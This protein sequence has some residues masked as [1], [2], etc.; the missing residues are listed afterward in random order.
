MEKVKTASEIY[1]Q[2]NTALHKCFYRAGFPYRQD[3]HVWLHLFCRI[4][5]R[6]VGGL[7]ELT[8]GERQR[9][10]RHFQKDRGMRVFVPGVP[11]SLE[12]WKKGDPESGFCFSE[13]EDPQVRMIYGM[14]AEM[15]Y[16][17]KALRGMVSRMFKVSDVRWLEPAD[18]TRLA[19]IVAAKARKKGCAVYYKR[20]AGGDG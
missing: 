10:L 17:P 1:K 4:A 6:R 15:G 8:L 19:K 11:Q 2:Q 3:K 14:W 20:E 12:G 16:E 7:S 18:Q 13:S 9:L 5:A